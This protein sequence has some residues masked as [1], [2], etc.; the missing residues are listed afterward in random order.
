LSE[1]PDNIKRIDVLKI[2]KAIQKPCRCYKYRYLI[3]VE[4]RL[5]YCQDCG[6]IVDPF[7]AFKNLAYHYEDLGKQ[8]EYLFEQWKQIINYKP[9]LL[10]F[11]DLESQY[12]S[13]K[14]LPRCPECGKAFFFE[15]IKSWTN[16]KM[17]VLRRE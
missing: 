6:A 3:D 1:L 14:M 8:V 9:W 16:R 13:G 17:E 7:D 4:N 12:R 15:H 10:V 11:R 5:V 2:E